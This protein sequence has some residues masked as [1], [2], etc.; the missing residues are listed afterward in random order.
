VGREAAEEMPTDLRRLL[1]EVRRLQR[2]LADR[3]NGFRRAPATCPSCGSY[4]TEERT[5]GHLDGSRSMHCLACR[6]TW[7]VGEGQP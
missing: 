3:R 6:H 7:R 1:A 4:T 2:L 5:V